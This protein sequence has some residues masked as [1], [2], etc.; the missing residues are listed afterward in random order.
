MAFYGLA[1]AGYLLRRRPAIPAVLSVPYY[2][3]LVN[4]AS[5]LGILDA[6]R[7]RTYTTWATP[8][9]RTHPQA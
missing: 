6:F 8:R 2:F 7:G 1:A 9:A 5:A 3:C 4:V